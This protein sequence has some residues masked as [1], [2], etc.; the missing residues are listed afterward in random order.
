MSLKV[1]V[2]ENWSTIPPMVTWCAP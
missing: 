1:D 2:N